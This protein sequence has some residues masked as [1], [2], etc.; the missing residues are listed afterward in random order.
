[1][2]CLG[3]SLHDVRNYSVGENDNKIVVVHPLFA[4]AAFCYVSRTAGDKF[5]LGGIHAFDYFAS[6]YFVPMGD[7]DIVGILD[8]TGHAVEVF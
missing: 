1:M 7:A 4:A 3:M 2:T 5:Y 8:E 6:I